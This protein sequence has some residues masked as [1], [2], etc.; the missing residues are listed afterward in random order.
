LARGTAWIGYGN[1]KVGLMISVT[2]LNGAEL[3][4]NDDLIEFIERTPETVLSMND[5]KKVTVKESVE[6]VLGRIVSFRKSVA[7]PEVI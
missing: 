7:L 2:R 1:W 6:E 3:V 4:V 5:G